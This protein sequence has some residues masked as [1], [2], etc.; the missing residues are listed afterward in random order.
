MEKLSTRS[1]GGGSYLTSA[2]TLNMESTVNNIQQSEYQ[3]QLTKD[4]TDKLQQYATKNL[5]TV[6]TVLQSL[7][8]FS[9][10]KY[11]KDDKILIGITHS[12]RTIS[13]LGIENI[14]GLFINTVQC[15]INF[16]KEL[17]VV[18]NMHQL[19]KDMVEV[20]SNSFIGLHR[21]QKIIT[22]KNNSLFDVVIVFENFESTTS[23]NGKNHNLELR[24]ASGFAKSE[25]PFTITIVPDENYIFT[26]SYDSTKFTRTFVEQLC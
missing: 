5:L 4:I 25:Y 15:S 12:G 3:F 21:I 26:I 14:I 13:C 7:I 10:G 20:L 11:I 24:M 9:L 2:V 18:E 8:G 22:G 23:K 1:R 17:T 16:N 19:Q 6:N